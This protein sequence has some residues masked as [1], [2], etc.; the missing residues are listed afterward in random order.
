MPPQ[1]PAAHVRSGNLRPAASIIL[2]PSCP[3]PN[4]PCA[5]TFSRAPVTSI[6]AGPFVRVHPDDHASH[7]Y[8]SFLGG[9]LPARRAALLRAG[10]TPLEPLRATVPGEAHANVRATPS[11]EGGQPN[12]RASRRSPQ[13]S[14]AR[15][16]P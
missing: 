11:N 12:E 8:L 14:L 16:R 5:R 13:P 2:Q 3:V 9:Q 7:G 1:P 15:H 6:V 4:R 10:Q